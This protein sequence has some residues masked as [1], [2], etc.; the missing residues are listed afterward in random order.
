MKSTFPNYSRHEGRR[1]RNFLRDVI[2][3]GQDGIVN[4]LGIVLGVSVASGDNRIIIAA[5]LAAAFSESI[6][7]GAVAYTSALSERDYYFKELER[8]INE[9]KEMPDN[10]MGEIRSIFEAQGFT[11]DMLDKVVATITSNKD[12]WVNVMMSEEL[13]LKPVER[14]DVL[15]TSGIVAISAIIGSLI[16]VAPF[17]ILERSTAAFASV[18]ISALALFFIGA[19]EAKSFVGD[20]RKKGIQMVIIGL[21]AALIGFTIGSLFS[22]H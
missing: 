12:I 3:G 7:M 19:Y 9:V 21:G 22:T 2:L 18:T 13:H 8:E 16:P 1:P 4:V 20:W 14:K 15:K 5:S 6:S 11:G 10:E 17:I